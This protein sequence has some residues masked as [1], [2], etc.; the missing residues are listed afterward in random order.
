MTRTSVVLLEW[1]PAEGETLGSEDRSIGPG[2]F[3]TGS[4]EVTLGR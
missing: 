1:G 3:F 2:F 4:I